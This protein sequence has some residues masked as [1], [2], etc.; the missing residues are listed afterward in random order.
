VV[1]RAPE[2]AQY[3]GLSQST[4]AKMR[5]RGGSDAPPF[6]RLGAR[7]V[8][9]RVEDLNAWLESRRRK[10]TSDTGNVARRP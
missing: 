10:S 1:I 3:L 4:L 5:M 6:V 2:A 7:V 8:G 9:Y